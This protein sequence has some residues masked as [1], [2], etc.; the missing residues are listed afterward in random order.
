MY[1][2][3][4]LRIQYP[5]PVFDKLETV[6]RFVRVLR[7]YPRS[8]HSV[9]HGNPYA[10]VQVSDTFDGSSFDVWA[11]APDA[12]S[13]VPRLKATEAAV[14]RLIQ[15]LFEEFQEGTVEAYANE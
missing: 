9:Q 3:A 7:E 6:R 8:M 12:I 14:A 5:Q 4:P 2:A 1:T 13:I 10:Y 11:L 15:W